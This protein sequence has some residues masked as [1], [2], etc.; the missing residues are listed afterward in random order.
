MAA[1]TMLG[2][3]RYFSLPNNKYI[4]VKSPLSQF[5]FF[6]FSTNNTENTRFCVMTV[7]E[8]V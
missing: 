8:I 2:E 3:K 6:T 1:T 5:I 4:F 7:S